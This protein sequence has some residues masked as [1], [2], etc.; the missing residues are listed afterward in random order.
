MKRSKVLASKSYVK[1]SLVRLPPLIRIQITDARPTEEFAIY[2]NYVR[3]LGFEEQ[4]DYDFLRD[5]FSK[6]L[7]SV[8]ETDDGMF[9]WLLLNNGQ[10]PFAT[11]N[12]NS[13]DRHMPQ[14]G[15]TGGGRRHRSSQQ[16]PNGPARQ[17]SRRG[18]RPDALN[19]QQTLGAD[20]RPGRGGPSPSPLLV[21]APNTGRRMSSGMGPHPYSTAAASPGTPQG[22]NGTAI[23]GHARGMTGEDTMAY[24]SHG[25]SSAMG[26]PN[27]RGGY[28]SNIAVRGVGPG[29][30]P[31]SSSGMIAGPQMMG[32]GVGMGAVQEEPREKKGF[33]ALLCCR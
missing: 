9:D 13:I 5:L 4:P 14:P 6:V 28:G 23:P 8:G 2:L 25:R 20:M 33:W 15:G 1:V 18:Q 29:Q 21:N 31:M 16:M 30:G 10:G 24:Q 22:Y 11:P 12:S 7:A 27:N 26:Y 3:K 17:G 19:T 32:G